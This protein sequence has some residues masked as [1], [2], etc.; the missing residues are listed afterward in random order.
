MCVPNRLKVVLEVRL[1]TSWAPSFTY[2]VL[3]VF[4]LTVLPDPTTN[5]PL[6]PMLVPEGPVG[7][8]SSKQHDAVNF[9]PSMRQLHEVVLDKSLTEHLLT[10]RMLHWILQLLSVSHAA[11]H[12]LASS[13]PSRIQLLTATYS[14]LLTY[15]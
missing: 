10:I 4:A 13:I 12:T 2:T 9:I 14:Y 3:P 6:V 5:V 15:Q 1:S 11:F 7:P 8:T